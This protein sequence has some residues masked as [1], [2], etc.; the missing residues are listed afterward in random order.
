MMI[1]I[2]ET[3]RINKGNYL[4]I[5]L[6]AISLIVSILSP[7]NRLAWGIFGLFITRIATM[8]FPA[9]WSLSTVI[10][11]MTTVFTFFHLLTNHSQLSPDID[12]GMIRLD[13]NTFQINGNGLSGTGEILLEPVAFY[14]QINTEAEKEYWT[15]LQMPVYVESGLIIEKPD[16]ATN[17][18]QFDYEQYLLHKKMHW[19]VKIEGIYEITPDYSLRSTY[20]KWRTKIL[21]YIESGLAQNKTHDYMMAML[22]NQGEDIESDIM[23]SYRKIG[24]LHIFSI[25]G[26]HI[27]FLI[28]AVQYCL[29][30]VGVTRETTRPLLLGVIWIYGFLTGAGVGVFRAIFTHTILLIA[31]I[32]GKEVDVKDAFAWAILVALWRNPYLVF[33]IAFQLSYTLSGLLYFLSPKLSSIKLPV[34]LKDLFLSFI[35]TSVSGIFLSYHYFEIPWMG[36]LVNIFFSFFISRLLFPIFW[37]FVV[38]SVI[39]FPVTW[40]GW[41]AHIISCFLEYF[42]KLSLFL[43]SRNWLLM[44]TGRPR[45]IWYVL[46][47]VILLIFLVAF[48]QGKRIKR[49]MVMLLIGYVLFYSLPNFSGEGRVIMLD[50]GQGDAILIKMPHRKQAILIDTG[51]LTTF[52]SKKEEWQ[53]RKTTDYQGRN[54]VSAIKA[55]GVTHLDA[56]FLTHSDHDHIGNLG[57]LANELNIATLYI[58]S[59]MEDTTPFIKELEEVRVLPEV[60]TLISPMVIKRDSLV[61]H[62]LNPE[63]K[64]AGENAHSLVLFS[65]IGGTNWL[66]TGDLEE[67]GERDLARRYPGLRVDILKVAHHGSDTSTSE[68]FL[69]VIEPRASFISVGRNNHYGHPT[70]AVI[71]RLKS[72][73]IKIYRTDKDGAIHYIFKGKEKNIEN[74]LQ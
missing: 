34:L 66:F 68:S 56:V 26:M 43:A 42:E 12:R 35:M 20:S 29:F 30:R 27:H 9:L 15:R 1:V 52:S 55:E 3:I 47:V 61:F 67:M 46:L 40:W 7:Q 14:Y 6:T 13:P 8:R 36:M 45:L 63:E 32:I 38:F 58:G 24:I 16:T 28:T 70:D 53:V 5:T 74:M 41:F 51:G 39:R 11:L 73:K 62:V 57:Y 37:V 72:K 60:I 31:G 23:A 50:V 69:E 25:S 33:S 48:E 18:F 19:T 59:G 2:K 64:Q 44:I 10:L 54:L 49:T 71:D 22:F 4:L 17:R 65:R 21:R